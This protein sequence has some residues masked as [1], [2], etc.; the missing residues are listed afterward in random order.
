MESYDPPKPTI[1]LYATLC[2]MPICISVMIMI[3]FLSFV[4]FVFTNFG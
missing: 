4:S 3:S 2:Y 1:F